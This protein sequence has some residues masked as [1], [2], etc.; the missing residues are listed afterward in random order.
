[1]MMNK[2]RHTEVDSSNSGSDKFL[3]QII[4]FL[5]SC[6]FRIRKIEQNGLICTS[7]LPIWADFSPLYVH[8]VIG[9][10]FDLVKFQG[11]CTTAET[12][13]GGDLRGHTAAVFIDHPPNV[14]DL[15]QIFA[16]R[17][18][19]EF[20]VVPVP[21]SLVFKSRLY[22]NAKNV[23]YE[24]LRLYSSPHN[25]Y[26]V[27]S[28]VN[29]ILTFFGRSQLLTKLKWFLTSGMS[30]IVFGV[31]KIGKTSLLI[32]LMDECIWP[33]AMIDLQGY[34]G[35]E[36]DHIYEDI[37]REWRVA[38]QAN[39][40][41][42]ILPKWTGI[43]TQV[44]PTTQV[45][46]FQQSAQELLSLLENQLGQPG[47]LLFIDE[48][49]ILYDAVFYFELARAL[50]GIAHNP[51]S[52]GRFAILAS[53]LEPILNRQPEINEAMN[54]FYDFFREIPLEPLTVDDTQV[55]IRAIGSQMGVTYYDDAIDLIVDVAGGHPFLCRQ[56]CSQAVQDL[57]QPLVSLAQA[58]WAIET[59]L[60]QPVNYLAEGLWN[61]S[62]N[63]PPSSEADILRQLAFV[64]PQPEKSLIPT[65]LPLKELR[66]FDQALRHLHDHRLINPTK[67]GWKIT[68][69]LYRLWIRRYIL[70]L[71][72]K[73][74]MEG[75]Q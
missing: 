58:S 54:P 27:R 41:E 22:G 19:R 25:L 56:L 20:T 65:N 34:I 9:H 70:Y 28:P 71:H 55:M 10:P 35:A 1:M 36:I 40:P 59:Y 21:F 53:G 50:R 13:Y 64:Q 4:Y 63:G 73:G 15:D 18:Q 30:A 31:R 24:Q 45:K 8:F 49:D 23:F 29:D 61:L 67:D 72:D 48:V 66:A 37:L 69:P 12:V 74:T 33:V 16:I 44:D 6:G 39:F 32:R 5:E 3:N 11:L 60:R 75:N 46:Y 38:I 7:D 47:L 14:N 26:D 43:S 57:D 2:R 52:K 42:V 62:I 17:I 51:R 68:Y